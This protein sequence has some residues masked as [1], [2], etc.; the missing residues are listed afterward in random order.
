MRKPTVGRLFFGRL[1]RSKS[2]MGS[3]LRRL[4]GPGAS[5]MLNLD[6]A[7]V[8]GLWF[9]SQLSHSALM[10]ECLAEHRGPSYCGVACQQR[11]S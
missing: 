10:L 3:P 6:V 11:G 5:K 1:A 7:A 2:D 9:G 8:V 4:A